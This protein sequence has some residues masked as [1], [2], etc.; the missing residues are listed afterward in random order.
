MHHY[1]EDGIRAKVDDRSFKI[2]LRNHVTGAVITVQGP[3]RGAFEQP[4]QRMDEAAAMYVGRE[5]AHALREI[6]GQ[7]TVGA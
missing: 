5:L 1:G 2:E 4:D 3:V 7:A 6:T